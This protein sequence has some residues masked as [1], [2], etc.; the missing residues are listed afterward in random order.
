MVIQSLRCRVNSWQ[1]HTETLQGLG[2]YSFKLSKQKCDQLTTI[3]NAKLTLIQPVLMYPE[4]PSALSSCASTR[5]GRVDKLA[6]FQLLQQL[7][8]IAV[9]RHQMYQM[10]CML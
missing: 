6:G 1:Q 8:C 4:F 10:L 9:S 5:G 7:K 2:R 3:S